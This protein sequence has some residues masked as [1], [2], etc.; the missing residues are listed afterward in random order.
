M[1]SGRTSKKG[2]RPRHTQADGMPEGTAPSESQAQK[3]EDHP[4]ESDSLAVRLERVQPL[5]HQMTEV[6][7]P[8]TVK[9]PA[10][11]VGAG[12]LGY[13]PDDQLQTVKERELTRG[14]VRGLPEG[15]SHSA[16]VVLTP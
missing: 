9:G 1:G 16:I 12:I 4:E 15:R 6:G 2:N 5:V 8:V 10:V 14:H 13:I 3:D 11:H 7:A